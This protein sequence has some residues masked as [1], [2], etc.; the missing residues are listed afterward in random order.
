MTSFSGAFMIL[1][2]V[3]GP[4]A[5]DSRSRKC[6]SQ[7]SLGTQATLRSVG[8]RVAIGSSVSPMPRGRLSCQDRPGLWQ[9]PQDF[10]PEPDSAGSKKSMRPSRDFASEL[11][12]LA[13]KGMAL[14]RT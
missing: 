5:T 14:G 12:L 2:L 1:A 3:I 13:G 7:A 8:V 10:V 4:K 11:G 6:P 9:L